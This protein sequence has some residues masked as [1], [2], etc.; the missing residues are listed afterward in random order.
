MDPVRAK[1][2]KTYRIPLPLAKRKSSLA[3]WLEK[4][5]LMEGHLIC[6]DVPESHN[7]LFIK[8]K[9]LTFSFKR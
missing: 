4:C 3:M 5:F 7:D 6:I 8:K 1:L 2:L 9:V